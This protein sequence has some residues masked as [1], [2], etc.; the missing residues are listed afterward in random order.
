MKK[1]IILLLAAAAFGAH[2]Q[3]P[4]ALGRKVATL[5]KN[6]Q[7]P[8]SNTKVYDNGGSTS[9]PWIVFSDRD[10][11]YTYTAPGGSLVMKKI[12]FME[13]FYV[14]KEQNGYLKLIKYQQGMVQGRKLTN[15]KGA[16]SY[17]WVSKEKVLL[18][19]SAFVTPQTGYPQK[20]IAIV[21]GKGPLTYPN[22]YYDKTDSL[23]V[24]TSPEMERKKTKVALHQL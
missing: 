7:R 22:V 16:Q 11:N 19:Q 8:V 10:E 1:L 15:K 12:K 18:W 9:L 23:L 2:A 17:G 14:S 6:F 3:S 4:V 5:P 24:F 20:A 21:S 13:P